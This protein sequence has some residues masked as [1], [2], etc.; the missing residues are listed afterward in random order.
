MAPRLP[1]ASKLMDWVCVGVQLAT[2]LVWAGL[3]VRWTEAIQDRAPSAALRPA[4]PHPL[5]PP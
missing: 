5:R 3:V 1:S 2:L 4:H